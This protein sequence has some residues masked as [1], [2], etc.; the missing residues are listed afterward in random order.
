M[1]K[2]NHQLPRSGLQSNTK[3]PISVVWQRLRRI[4]SVL[5]VK[6]EIM[7][8][9]SRALHHIMP[10]TKR[11]LLAVAGVLWDGLTPLRTAHV[12]AFEP[13]VINCAG[14]WL[15]CTQN[16]QTWT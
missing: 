4:R 3:D 10:A 7:V 12:H 6:A 15:V 2:Q 11:Q 14:S 9:C 1:G 16:V 13:W 8:A 5:C